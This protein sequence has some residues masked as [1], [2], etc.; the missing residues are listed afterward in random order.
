MSDEDDGARR[1]I[2]LAMVLLDRDEVEL[3]AARIASAH[4]ELSPRAPAL[5]EG[6]GEHDG[7][8]AEA[9]L[10][11]CFVRFADGQ[12]RAFLAVLPPIPGGEAE[13][14]RR[15]SVGSLRD[16]AVEP[17]PHAAHVLVTLVG[18]DGLEGLRRLT[19]VAAAVARATEATGVHWGGGH[20]THDAAF[21]LDVAKDLGPDDL[22]MILWSGV[23]IAR[24]ARGP[25]LLSLGMEQLG[26]PELLVSAGR[27]E[28][29]AA[30]AF[31]FDLLTY[32][33]RRG[34]AV[35]AGETVGRSADERLPVRAAPSP[36][37]PER[38]VWC[39]DLPGDADATRGGA[40]LVALALLIAGAAGA[41]FVFLR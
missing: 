12:G 38:T 33:A 1:S 18:A 9:E 13:A 24:D 31:F 20:V 28:P 11:S 37:D 32:A 22:P 4:R 5:E 25:S 7:E 21:F 35:A 29:R 6:W 30:L 15:F 36:V 39:V 17:P 26:Q 41:W 34:A 27:T 40:L 19:M 14:A 23:S 16:G 2:G 10:E 8:E 3:D